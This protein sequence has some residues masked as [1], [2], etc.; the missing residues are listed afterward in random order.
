MGRHLKFDRDEALQKAMRLF[1]ERGYNGTSIQNLID[2]IGIKPG[3]FYNTF[4]DKHSIFL[5]SL[6]LYGDFILSYSRDTLNN[7]RSPVENINTFFRDI[8]TI[9][10]F[11]SKGCLIVKTIVEVVPKNDEVL[12]IV[13]K[14]LNELKSCFYQCLKRGQ[15]LGEIPKDKD[16]RALSSFFAS[17][18]DGLILSGK[19]KISNREMNSIVKVIVS[20][21]N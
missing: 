3:S 18:T 17:A 4:K 14:I 11:K 10:D 15:E 5:E 6:N 2:E 12:G 13:N 9:P 21:V 1:W 20:T 8:A 7:D 19:T 16:I